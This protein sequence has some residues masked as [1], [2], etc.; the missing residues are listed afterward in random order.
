[1]PIEATQLIKEIV[2]E[3]LG[4]KHAAAQFMK[5]PQGVLTAKGVSDADLSNVN[6]RQ[7]VGDACT[8]GS[9]PPAMSSALQSYA[10][11]ESGPS[12]SGHQSVER[13]VQQLS[14]VTNVAYHDDHSVTDNSTN[15]DDSV[16][17][18]G[19]VHGNINVD[20]ANATG[21]GA[22][23]GSGDGHVAG[24]TGDH[25]QAIGG[26]NSGQANTG[27]GAV[28][29]G[30]EPGEHG[31]TGVIR[32]LTGVDGL[33]GGIGPINTGT[34]TGVMA[35]GGVDHTIVG[36]HDTQA[37]VQGSVSDSVF[38]FG[39]GDVSNIGHSQLTDSAVGAGGHVSNASGNTLGQGSAVS[40]GGD[41]GGYSSDS[42]N[43]HTTTETSTVDAHDSIVGV[44]QGHGDLNQEG[45]IH[46][47]LHLP[48]HPVLEPLD[49]KQPYDIDHHHG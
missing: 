24:A 2:Q 1:M 13:V 22:V 30:N 47:D 17:I 38:N 20:N 37:N 8:S 25:S 11:G 27:D 46:N 39:G 29:I 19:D 36:D 26:D 23:A 41:A 28:Q 4:D 14:Y 31:G 35:G 33:G 10:S 48:P 3:I 7:V 12:S 18:D 43:V 15:I 40:S 16:N 49:D 45:H 32:G 44:D 42:H 34:N 9:V 5:D 21:D 6:V